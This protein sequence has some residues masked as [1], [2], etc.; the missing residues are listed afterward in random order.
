MKA[1]QKY[2]TGL[3]N[4]S[5]GDAYNRFLQGNQLNMAANQNALG[6]YN[7]NRNFGNDQRNEPIQYGESTTTATI[8]PV[9]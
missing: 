5:Y 3:A 7:T 6:Q 1:L 2:G 9:Q 4:Q 8:Q